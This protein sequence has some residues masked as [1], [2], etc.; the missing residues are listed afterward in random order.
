[1]GYGIHKKQAFETQIVYHPY[2]L[3]KG[4]YNVLSHCQ[5]NRIDVGGLVHPPFGMTKTFP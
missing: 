2:Y 5:T 4:P 1:M 3:G